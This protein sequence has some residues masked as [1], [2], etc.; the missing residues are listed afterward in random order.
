[1][2]SLPLWLCKLVSCK[3]GQTVH[4]EKLF[5]LVMHEMADCIIEPR[6]VF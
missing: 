2:N 5:L 6:E 4:F 1:M 3:A